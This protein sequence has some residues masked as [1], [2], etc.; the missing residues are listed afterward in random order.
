MDIR[1]DI[2]AEELK[3]MHATFA[4]DGQFV[5]IRLTEA[6]VNYL[7]E[8]PEFLGVEVIKAFDYKTDATC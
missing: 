7:R 4:W 6:G 8:H 1:I 2:P 5:R 3:D